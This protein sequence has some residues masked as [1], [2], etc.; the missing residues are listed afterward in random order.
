M[1]I[2]ELARAAHMNAVNK[3]F[4]DQFNTLRDYSLVN[5]MPGM[6]Y[7]KNIH[8]SNLIMLVVTELAEAVEG[9]RKGNA[10]NLAEE[11]ADSVIRIMD[12]SGFLEIDLEKAIVEKMAINAGRPELHN[13][14]F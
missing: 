7:I 9:L 1:K 2:K 4:Y 11:L 10:E 5:P 8:I 6:E 13:K 12:L 14:K 3:G